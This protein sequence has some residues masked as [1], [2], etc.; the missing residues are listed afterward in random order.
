MRASTLKLWVTAPHGQGPPAVSNHS[1]EQFAQKY[2]WNMVLYICVVRVHNSV[3][4]PGDGLYERRSRS[5]ATSTTENFQS[6]EQSLKYTIK[7]LL[8]ATETNCTKYTANYNSSI[9]KGLQSWV[10][11]IHKLLP[12]F[13]ISF[14]VKD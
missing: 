7:N 12:H 2:K 9:P 1:N 13:K 11:K 8:P 14:K 6:F 5:G 10:S 4:L 3:S